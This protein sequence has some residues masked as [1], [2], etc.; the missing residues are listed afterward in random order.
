MSTG[1]F[2]WFVGIDCGSEWH[3]VRLLAADGTDLGERRVAHAGHALNELA[4]WLAAQSGGHPERVA[5]AIEV[6]RGAVV[7]GLLARGFAVFGINPKQLDRFRDR[8]SV[9]GAKDDRRDAFVLADTLRSDRGRYRRLEV[10]DPQLIALRA[11]VEAHEELGEEVRRLANRLRAVLERY[12]PQ[13]LALAPAADEP[14][15]W[16]LLERV[17]T[18][19]HATRVRA[20]QV[21]RVLRI[22]RIRRIETAEVLTILRQRALPVA[23]GTAEAAAGQALLLVARLRLAHRQRTQCDQHVAAALDALAG[24]DPESDAA[25]LGSVPALG[26]TIAAALLVEASALLAARDYGRLRC[27][28]G[29]AP[30]TRRSGKRR[31]VVMRRACSARLRRAMFHWA[32]G[33]MQRTP[34]GRAIYA[35]A[36]ARGQSHGR[37]LRGLADRLLRMLIAMLRT[38]TPYDPQRLVVTA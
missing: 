16:T 37:A 1:D 12:Y 32:F 21:T 31:E 20:A 8:Y 22:H 3:D 26:T 11:R 36:R 19:A 15:L 38:R 33:S 34:H 4:D 35:A 28:T 2:A 6:T 29:I 17:P 30:V 10:A 5:V 27:Q 23:P 18:P 25:L 9:A 14:W 24:D 13:L 7:E